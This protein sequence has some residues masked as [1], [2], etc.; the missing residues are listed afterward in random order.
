MLATLLAATAGLAAQTHTVRGTVEDV[1]NTTNQFV[2][3]CTNI[4][5]VSTAVNLNAWIGTE[6]IMQV[7]NLGSPAAP[8]LRVDAIAVTA[9]TF[10]MG[11]LRFG[12]ARTWTV[13]APAGSFS[14]VAI[15]FTANTGFLPVA[16]LGSYLLGAN[17]IVLRS[18]FAGG[19]NQFQFQFT[20]PNAPALTGQS[21]TAQALILESA[22]AYLS[23]SDCKD[24]GQ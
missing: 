1:Q 5:L 21:M 12:Q 10:E 18:G 3:K 23:N 24:I 13:F 17:A 8:S 14:L 4:P 20:M 7:T 11:N 9:E 19:N 6:A 16:G 15:D 2:L 22:Q